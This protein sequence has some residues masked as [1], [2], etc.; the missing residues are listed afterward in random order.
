[1]IYDPSVKLLE[2]AVRDRWACHLCGDPVL[3]GSHRSGAPHPLGP[4]I[5]HIVPMSLGGAHTWEN[6]ALAHHLCNAL[7]GNRVQVSA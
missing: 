5:D 3:K 4:S 1:M 2:V 7:K 6:V